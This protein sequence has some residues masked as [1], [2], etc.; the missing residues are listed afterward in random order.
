MI[1][2]IRPLLLLLIVFLPAILHAQDGSAPRIRMLGST[3]DSVTGGPPTVMVERISPV[4]YQYYSKKR[5]LVG[6]DLVKSLF[7]YNASYFRA[8]NSSWVVGGTV[9]FAPGFTGD[10]NIS[11]GFGIQA[12]TK[13]FFAGRGP[14]GWHGDGTLLFYSL[15]LAGKDQTPVSFTL[16][17]G[18]LGD[19]GRFFVDFK[20]GVEYF[21]SPLAE[22]EKNYRG[23]DDDSLPMIGA[24][25]D[26]LTI[27]SVLLF[28]VNF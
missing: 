4:E 21:L 10:S 13:Y 6:I 14:Y 18:Y 19:F 20:V 11:R 2:G 7:Y 28:G 23:E 16:D 1:P 15:R 22:R 9:Q 27:H 24:E 3:A 26:K 5:N 17:G 25:G 8:L 12:G